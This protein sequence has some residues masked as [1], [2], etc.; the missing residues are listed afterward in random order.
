MVNYKFEYLTGEEI[1]P[2]DQRRVIKQ[3][4]FTYSL[5]GKALKKQ[6]KAIED[7]GKKKIKAIED[8]GKQVVDSNEFIKKDFNIDSYNIQHE[9]QKSLMNLLEKNVLNFII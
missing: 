3:V 2:S 8:H 5:L 7:Q 1:L 4:K 9:E 6:K